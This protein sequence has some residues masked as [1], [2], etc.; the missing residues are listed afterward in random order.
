VDRAAHVVTAEILGQP[1]TAIEKPDLFDDPRF[2][3]R[4]GRI[5]NQAILI[6]MLSAIFRDRDRTEWCRRLE[7]LDV[8][9]APVYETSEVPDDPQARHLQL[10][11]DTKHPAGGRWRTVRSP[12]TY[13]G[14]RAL[15]VTAPPLLGE[16]NEA[17]RD[18]WTP[19]EQC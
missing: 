19:R 16:H 7:A 4:E 9:Y 18:G 6:G 14:E 5:T 13:D 12:V 3:S 8:P 10:F 2:A 11:V 15:D 1:A 17:L